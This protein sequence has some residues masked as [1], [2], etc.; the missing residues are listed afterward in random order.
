[1]SLIE[2]HLDACLEAGLSISGINAE[3]MPGQWEFQVGP[4]GLLEVGRP[5]VDGP[6]VA[7]PDR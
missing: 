2:D 7:L 4:V 1:M 5:A 6:L 3:V